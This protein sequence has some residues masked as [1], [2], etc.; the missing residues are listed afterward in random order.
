MISG[1]EVGANC[2]VQLL[3]SH[4]VSPLLQGEQSSQLFADGVHV[5]YMNR[6]GSCGL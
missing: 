6:S 1:D 5:N 3:P 2:I 4:S